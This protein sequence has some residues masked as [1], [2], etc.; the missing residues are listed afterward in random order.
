MLS[1]CL[2]CRKQTEN[3]NSRAAKSKKEKKTNAFVKWS[4]KCEVC[5]SKKMRFM[6]EKKASGSLSNLKLKTLLIKFILLDDTLF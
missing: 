2:K 6:K 3:K 4:V 1:H 5:N